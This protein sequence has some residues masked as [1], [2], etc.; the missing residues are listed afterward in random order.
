MATLQRVECWF[1]SAARKLKLVCACAPLLLAKSLIPAS[2]RL[3]PWGVG[4]IVLVALL[5]S[6]ALAATI[7]VNSLADPGSPGTCSLR[8]AIT[9]AN[10]MAATNGC[11]AG[12][13][14]DTIQF[15]VIGTITLAA[16]LPE[17]AGTLTITGPPLR[18]ITISGGGAVQVMRVASGATLNLKNLTV[19]DG[20]P[21]DQEGGGVFNEGTLTVSN[22]T[23]T[24]N[25]VNGC[26]NGISA[27]GG[28][29][30]NKGL[31]I[32]KDSTFSRNL[33]WDGGAIANVSPDPDSSN[34]TA[35]IT[36]STFSENAINEGGAAIFG[37]VL[38]IRNSTFSNNSAQYGGAILF[39]LAGD[40]NTFNNS[41]ITN[42]T[43]S[44]NVAL[45]DGAIRVGGVFSFCFP[46]VFATGT[47]E[48]ASTSNFFRLNV[49]N[50]TFS[51][52][53]S[54]EGRGVIGGAGDLSVKSTILA[55]NSPGNCSDP[56]ITTD[57]GYN[58]SD[59]STCGFTKTGSANNG[60]N[61]DPL[62]SPAG[63]SDNGGPTK[64]IALQ[65]GSPAIDAI[66]VADCTDQSSPPGPIAADQRGF[67][68]LDGQETVCDIGAYE[69]QEVQPSKI[70]LTPV[71]GNSVT[72]PVA[73]Y[74]Q[75]GKGVKWLNVY[76]DGTYLASSPPF[77]FSWD[78]S[79]FADGEHKISAVAYGYHDQEVSSDEV[80]VKVSNPAVKID[81]PAQNSIVSGI[82]TI[83]TERTQ[84][85]DWLNVYIDGRYFAS[86]PPFSFKWD[87]TT[88]SDGRHTISVK[89][90]R[91]AGTLLESTSVTITVANLPIPR[92]NAYI[93]NTADGT[94]SVISTASETVIAT[95]PA[96]SNTTGVAVTP[97]GSKVY[98]AGDHIVSVISTVT[99]TVIA[100]IPV[101]GTGVPMGVAVTPDGSKVYVAN[102]SDNTVSV[103]S[104]ATNK[105]IGSPIPVGVGPSGVA[106][107]PDGSKVYVANLEDVS[108][109]VISTAT[110]KVINSIPG[111]N[112]PEGLA[113]TPDGSKV[114][115]TNRGNVDGTT[116]SVIGTS[117]D[118]II[119]TI[120][121]GRL[122]EG[123]AVTPDG[124]K[125]YVA[126]SSS[127]TVS[128]ISTAT[129]A[130]VAT[131]PEDC[132]PFSCA[133]RGLGVT[134]D[135]TTL[136]VANYNGPVSSVSLYSTATN[137]PVGSTIL[138]GGNPFPFGLFFQPGR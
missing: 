65:P 138:V 88:V 6:N 16:T 118:G 17:I 21:T 77:N 91:G 134:P 63:L 14:D 136:Y 129:N 55:A 103:I 49:S 96:G 75:R 67:P 107:T 23:F 9:A 95:I 123:V 89:G 37:G 120:S 39:Q 132:S 84:E 128:V 11:A 53:Q 31:L 82:V 60:D 45:D 126:N 111:F 110:N 79:K 10:T 81:A 1:E 125:V 105:V 34:G 59:D 92:P 40:K 112:H 114:Y 124:N 7:T 98:V 38:T 113:I 85:V 100:T 135:G 13:G 62:L 108:V 86:S 41:A 42:S 18:R 109:S 22:S 121:V 71:D 3:R 94:V 76:V 117:T 47:E 80:T 30:R 54:F 72:G 58:I 25:I 83:D 133:A 90:Y 2:A 78:S 51:S 4:V 97:D 5:R 44:G 102:L 69:F 119:A 104:A 99:N 36:N 127:D 61:V 33:A 87:S 122:P 74:T 35:I 8:D 24:G 70:I 27:S 131:I 29:I 46:P 93:T 106:V 115:V 66:P 52:N 101:P 130:V 57:T 28:A 48:V 56:G 116:V 15:S 64:T 43:F 137:L 50:S 32:V 20:V 26:V 73:I 68:R 19:A 12:T